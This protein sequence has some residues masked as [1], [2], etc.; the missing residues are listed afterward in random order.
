MMVL[1]KRGQKTLKAAS[2]E[3]GICYRQTKRIY[4][5]N[6]SGGDDAL[7]HGNK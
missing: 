2:V 5:R 7:V 6:L 1:V 4:Q 3:L